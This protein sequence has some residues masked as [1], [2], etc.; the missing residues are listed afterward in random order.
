MKS[1]VGGRLVALG[2]LYVP[3]A[4][5]QQVLTKLPRWLTQSRG[6]AAE[7]PTSAAIT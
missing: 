6:D 2:V 5:C 4:P 1:I 7:A 3:P